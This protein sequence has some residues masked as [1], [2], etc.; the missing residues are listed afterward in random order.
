[1]TNK[2]TRDDGKTHSKPNREDRGVEDLSLQAE[3]KKGH[4][5]GKKE[6]QNNRQMEQTFFV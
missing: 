2:S 1:L 3:I 4:S 5:V 6:G